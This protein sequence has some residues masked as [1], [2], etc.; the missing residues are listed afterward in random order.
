MTSS[1]NPATHRDAARAGHTVRRACRACGLERLELFLPLGDVALAN[2]FL[3]D[4]S[5]F[6]AEQR[7]PLEVYLCGE[8]GM[9]QLADVIDPEAL[10]SNYLYVTG[11]S[12]TIAEHNRG[13]AARVSELLDLGA[14]DLVCEI[15]SN[16]GSLLKCFRERGVRTLGIEPASNIAEGANA[17][18]I[19]TLNR[20]LDDDSAREVCASHG[21]GVAPAAAVI[22]NNVL[23]HVDTPVEF[24]RAMKLLTRPDGMVIVEVPQL[25]E[26]IERLEYDTVYHEHLSYFSANA[27]MRVCE[28]AQLSIVRLERMPVHGGTLRMYATH[29]ESVPEH[30]PEVRALAAEERAAGLTSI[31]RMRRFAEDVE[32][33]RVA[34][35]SL[36]IGLREAGHT[37]AGY[38]APAKGNTLLCYCDIGTDLVPYTVDKSPLK[39]G[40]FTP[41][42]HLPV[43]ETGVLL[44]RQP[45]YVLILAWNFAEEIMAQQAEYAARGGRFIL[46]L[47]SPRV[48]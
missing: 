20:F 13:Y 7:Y 2:S 5:E 26:F 22:G 37:V 23:A 1:P 15:A 18:G 46:P 14:D 8:C 3:R 35:R 28:E 6:A 33:Q 41:G 47:P 36:L 30:A 9:V 27:L 43:L 44:E 29:R 32:A 24:L 19:E 21:G 40:L 34:L 42:M 45:D 48:V 12:D 31:A 4:E 38:G 17:D 10:F 11:T 39:V 25:R 16:D